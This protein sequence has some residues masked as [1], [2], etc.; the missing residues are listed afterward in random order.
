MNYSLLGNPWHNTFRK[1]IS[2]TRK[3]LTISSPFVNRGGI[4]LLN[5]FLSN[6]SI[7]INLITNIS[8]SNVLNDITQ[9]E[10]IMQLYNKFDTNLY[11][12]GSL[13]AKV[14]IADEKQV[15][16]TSANLTSGGIYNN[17]EY[18][19]LIDDHTV[20]KEI[21]NDVLEY[22]SLGNLIDIKLLKRICEESKNIIKIKKKKEYEN[23]ASGL[24]KLLKQSK[25]N[26]QVEVIQNQLNKGKSINAI[27]SET[28]LYLLKIKGELTTK[29]L[30]NRVEQ[31]HPD[32][33]DDTIH[34]IIDGQDFGKKWKHLV[35]NAQQSLKNK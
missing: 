22:A 1:F 18:G 25:E 28:I 2:E 4:E 32:M 7:Q 19:V 35:R 11:S 5:N 6:K 13:H 3:E 31:V 9:P 10:A 16:V 14:F 29:E 26:F 34:R 33:C 23:E 17:F 20:A 24:A 12:L 30:N 15:I 21:K 8:Y 27:F